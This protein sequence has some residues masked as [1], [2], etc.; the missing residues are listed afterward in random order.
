MKRTYHEHNL[1]AREKT[2]ELEPRPAPKNSALRTPVQH[3]EMR[4]PFVEARK[5]RAGLRRNVA[6]RIVL[7]HEGLDRVEAIEPHQRGEFILVVQFTAHQVDVAEAGDGNVDSLKS[8]VMGGPPQA[9]HNAAT[10]SS[11]IPIRPHVLA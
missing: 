11:K 1:R 10:V 8:H 7:T 4:R 5:H 3:L 6:D 9:V 2:A